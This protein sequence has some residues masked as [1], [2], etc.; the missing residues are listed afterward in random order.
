MNLSNLPYRTTSYDEIA[1][2][3]PESSLYKEYYDTHWQNRVIVIDSDWILDEP[4][5]LDAVDELSPYY[6]P[7]DYDSLPFLSCFSCTPFIYECPLNYLFFIL[8][9]FI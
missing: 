7:D 6:N 8:S 4:L 9:H 3:L 5:D 1:N 2:E